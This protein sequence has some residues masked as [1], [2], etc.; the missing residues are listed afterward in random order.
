MDRHHRKYNTDTGLENFILRL[1]EFNSDLEYYSDYINSESKVKIR[2]KK[3]GNIFERYASCV[4]MNRKIRCYSCEKIKTKQRK[5]RAKQLIK[6]KKYID[7]EIQK[8]LNSIQLKMNICLQCNKL[9]IGTNKYC[10]NECRKK[11]HNTVHSEIRKRY[12][13]NNGHIDKTITLEKLIKRDNNV[14]YICNREC[15]LNDYT[16]SGNTFIAGNYYP[17]IDHVIPIAKGG[18][19]EWNNIRLAHRICNSLKSDKLVT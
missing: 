10:S 9:F 6:Y 12:K 1:R 3:C 7:K 4:R 8:N 14:C 15:N 16:F 18:T 5:E 2:C 17:S 11:Y 19:H 13:R